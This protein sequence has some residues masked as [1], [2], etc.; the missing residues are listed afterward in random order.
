ME[1]YKGFNINIDQ[2]CDAQNPRTE[3]DNLG[4]MICG[5]RRYTLG[6]EQYNNDVCSNWDEAIAMYMFDTYAN[7]K[8]TSIDSYNLNN[9][10]FS[11][12]DDENLA[13]INRWIERHVLWMPLYLYDHSS[14]TMNTTG[15]SCGWD[16]GTVGF[17]YMLK[18]EA[19][20]NWSGK[21]YKEFAE[22]YLKSEVTTYDQYISGEVYSYLIED[23][24]GDNLDSCS[25]FYGYDHEK[26]GLMEYAKN[27]IDCHIATV[28]EENIKR[29]KVEI[30]NHVP[31][32]KREQLT[33]VGSQA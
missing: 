1:N 3:W 28:K 7:E 32:L 20:K 15:F 13:K 2:D 14:I 31:L 16:S 4:K 6:D 9:Y 5:H 25:G 8:L 29:L 23:D 21:K 11:G 27:A 12:E 19:M 33:Y 24:V 17:I 18:S 10:G 30:Q 26:S 22:A